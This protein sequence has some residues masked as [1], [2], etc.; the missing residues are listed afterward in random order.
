MLVAIYSVFV[1]IFLGYFAKVMRM[2]GNRQGNILLGFLLNFSLPAAIFNGVY[3]SEITLS[4]MRTFLGAFSCSLIGGV[5]IFLISFYLCKYQKSLAVTMAF[6]VMLH[7]TLFLGVPIVGGA[8]G[9]DVAHKAI[10]FDKFCTSIPLAILTPLLMSFSGKGAFTI[11]AVS[12]RLFRNPLFL[13]MI[14]G[15]VL[16]SLPFRIPDELFAPIKALAICA[17]PVALFAIGVQLSFADVKLEWKNSLFV[18]AFGMGVVPV[19]YLSSLLIL[20]HGFG[21]IIDIDSQMVLIEIAMPPLISSTAIILRAGL[22]HKLAI[23]TIVIGIFLCG[24][25]TPL[26]MALSRL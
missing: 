16:K 11:Q 12:M 8:L 13:A 22:N 7:N 4:L 14:T 25:A 17:T 10:L 18:L 2:L 1:F 5:L 3:H 23:S 9:E 19:L 6:L 21:K 26:W 24:V 15:F 20:A